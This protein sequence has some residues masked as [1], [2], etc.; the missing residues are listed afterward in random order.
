[1][2]IADDG[3]PATAIEI[4]S[5]EHLPAW[6]ERQDAAT[7]AW[8]AAAG[9]QAAANETARLPDAEGGPGTVLAG[10]GERAAFDSLGALPLALP[11]GDYRLV[12]ANGAGGNGNGS[13]G[14]GNGIDA[15]TAARLAL[16]WGLGGYQFAAYKTPKR[17]PARLLLPPAL[18]PVRD[19]VD[20][21][22]L[23]RDIVNTPT[24]D[25]LPHH[26]EAAAFKL[27]ME[28]DAAFECT[29]GDDLT[30]RGFHA[31]HAVG[32]A[33]A[34]PPRLI[35]LR[36]GDGKAPKITLVGKGV[37]FDSGGLDLKPAAGMRLMKKDLGGAAHVLG[38][39]RLV[40]ARRLPVCLRVLVPAV[41][42][43]VSANAYRPGDVLR[44]YRGLTVEI[45][46][47]DAEGRLILADA[48]ALAADD[49]PDALID[50]ATLTGAARTALGTQ[51]PA[52]FSNCDDVA[53]GI[54]EAADAAQDPVWR[55]PLHAPYRRL[56][57]SDIADLSNCPSAPY[58]GAIAAALFLE[59][60][61]D[62]VPWAHFDVMAW[63]LAARPAH[64]AGG[65]AMGLRAV[66]GYIAGIAGR[67]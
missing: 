7:R 47:T 26:L 51:L 53:R 30:R 17:A 41:E 1:M 36:W 34:S 13:A 43:A 21:V 11:E 12:G 4:L 38:L 42:N 20:A 31:I 16:G 35:D 39:A 67:A 61:V 63:N 18:H 9:F 59:R 54:A 50:F 37:C 60:F 58:A 66:Y 8:V 64:P 19:E 49:R 44:T 2:L 57:D 45:E 15:E 24:E 3:R 55:M 32:R 40:M 6:L 62:G 25:M 52:L 46:N 10:L 5:R 14:G 28:Y 48:L 22:A 29:A 65:E 33:S 56:L 23:C 27:A